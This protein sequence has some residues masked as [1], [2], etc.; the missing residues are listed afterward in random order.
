ME[1]EHSPLIRRTSTA[2]ALRHHVPVVVLILVLGALA[3]WLYGA[4]TPTTYTSTTRVLV[5][6]SVG[7]PFAPT[8]ASVRED[9]LTSLETE[10]QVVRSAEV[11][12]S[13]ARG[14]NLTAAELQRGVGV[15]VPANTQILQI[16]LSATD[17]AVARQL[18]DA[19]AAA[20]LANRERRFDKVTGLRLESIETQTLSVVDDLR[21]A[22]AAAQTGTPA[23]RAFNAE[24]ARALSNELENLRAQRTALENSETPAGAVIAPATVGVGSSALAS[25]AMPL[26]GALAGLVLGCLLAVLLERWRDRVRSASDLEDAGLQVAAAMSPA[27]R[28]AGGTNDFDDTVR[29]LRALLLELEPRPSVVAVAPGEGATPEG[30]VSDALATSLARAG[31]RVVLVETD[32]GTGD[33]A[34][35]ETGDRA[36][37]ASL[38][39]G[40]DGLAEILEHERLSA[41]GL[42]QPSVE[43]LLSILPAGR[44][45]SH[46]RELLTTERLSGV[47]DPLVRE[48]YIVVVQCP[49]LETVDGEAVVGTADL[50]VVVATAGRTRRRA[51]EAGLRPRW[52]SSTPVV[53]VLVLA[54][55]GRRLPRVGSRFGRRPNGAGA[56]QPVDGFRA[57]RS[58]GFTE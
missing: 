33:Q 21:S 41:P 48:G 18:A 4:S 14:T 56:A 11:L 7:N 54:Q 46:T 57:E 6:P 37:A 40:V 9:E 31:H 2:R 1:P 49:G 36:G 3:G 43:P 25:I 13:V 29:R 35:S 58:I 12:R 45:T 24:L 17:P 16:S 23:E 30:G 42:L 50:A 32:A 51:L 5:N 55:S 34:R 15:V 10:A 28:R 26:G 27:R 52:G 47:L 39:I 38:A 20:Y 8:P 53:G 19:V 44:R 22:T